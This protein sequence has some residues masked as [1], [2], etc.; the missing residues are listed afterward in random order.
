MRN[1]KPRI[2]PLLS[3]GLF[4]LSRPPEISRALRFLRGARRSFLRTRFFNYLLF[5]IAVV[6]IAFFKDIVVAA[7]VKTR[8]ESIEILGVEVVLRNS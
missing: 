8:V 1:E 6:A 2:Q 5:L 3:A 7:L 4:A